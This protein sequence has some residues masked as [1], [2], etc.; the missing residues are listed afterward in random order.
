MENQKV[1]KM[2][3]VAYFAKEYEVK[4][5]YFHMGYAAKEKTYKCNSKLS[6]QEAKDIDGI[7]VQ[8]YGKDV[9]LA[10]RSE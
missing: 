10:W 3:P 2:A 5:P 9:Y 4:N 7:Y 1:V 6:C 8:R